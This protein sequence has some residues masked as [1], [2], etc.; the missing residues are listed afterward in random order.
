VKGGE[1]KEG[2][3]KGEIFLPSY[4]IKKKEGGG[5]RSS[6]FLVISGKENEVEEE[7]GNSPKLV[8]KAAP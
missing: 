8:R 3:K 7:K 4:S 1:K 5:R 6:T 2:E